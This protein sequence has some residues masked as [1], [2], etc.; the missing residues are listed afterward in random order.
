MLP[1]LPG[2][3]SGI[4]LAVI[5]CIAAAMPYHFSK[6]LSL[7]LLGLL[8]ASVNGQQVLRQTVEYSGN[9]QQVI[10]WVN[11]ASLQREDEHAVVITLQQVNGKRVF[12]PLMAKVASDGLPI[13]Y[14]AGQRWLLSMS[15]RPV[16]S[17]LNLGGFDGQR[18][19]MANRQTL[20]GRIHSAQPLSGACSLRQQK[21]S[22]VTQQTL[23][24]KN[25]PVLLALAFGERGLISQSISQLF[26][27]TGTAH[28]MAISGLHIGV[29]ALIGWLAARGLQ[30]LL[31]MRLIDYRFPIIISWCAMA[32]YG[33]L[34]GMNPPAMRAALAITLWLLLRL[35]RVRCDPWQVWSWG[36][37]LLMLSDPLG[38]LS[39]SF[40]LS[41]FAVAGLI[42]WFQWAPLPSRFSRHWYW[43]WVRWGHLQAGMTFLLLP[44]QIGLFHG[45]SS[46]S[47]IANL[48]AVPIVSLFTVPLVLVA[49]L[50]NHFPGEVALPIINLL[51]A[52]ADWSLEWVLAGLRRA[53]HYWLPVGEAALALSLSGWIA[54]IIWRMGWL[55]THAASVIALCGLM[56]CWR[57]TASRENWRLDM[58]DVGHGLAILIEKNGRGI[59]Y[60]TGNRWQGG[61]QAEMQ[62]LPYLQ[63]RNIAVDQIIVSHSHLDHHGGTWLVKA[64]FPEAS[65]R[66]AFT[67]NLPCTRGQAWR[68]QDLDFKVL[69]PPEQKNYAKNDDSCVIKVSDG[70]FSVLLSGDIEREAETQ[71]LKQSRKDLRVNLLQVP[72]HGSNTSSMG[73]FLRATGAEVAIA[74]AARFSAWRLPSEKIK[75]RYR[76]NDVAWRDTARS[77]QISA[78]FFDNYW[79]VKG[80]R[81]ELMPRWYHQWF[82]V[83]GDNE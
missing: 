42:F 56:L 53:E 39:D 60:D 41:C 77:G 45:F 1:A 78:F 16:H 82:G 74:S 51:W 17:Q 31:P 23:S 35:Y 37:A 75:R 27:V 11:S 2:L 54:V 50:L 5:A 8:W 65:V 29:A 62:I 57:Q 47:F 49:L 12:P 7:A 6:L 72:H 44:M 63:W 76:E 68:W 73:P 38:I 26:R 19:A 9:R 79:L 4:A 33:W 25:M 58:L 46:A 59:L 66:T 21:I 24:L 43:A 81:E 13:E 71:L 67:G 64:A 55:T 36:V 61:S 69:W 28:L 40:W 15:L 80:L 22:A 14:C 48:W 34:S 70:K 10:A 52:L 20:R 32:Y 30:Y 83:R 3:Y 18:W